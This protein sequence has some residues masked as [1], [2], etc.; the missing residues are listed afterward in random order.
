MGPTA[1]RKS[2]SAVIISSVTQKLPSVTAE[3]NPKESTTSFG[4]MHV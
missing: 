2:G 3:S 1:T 4:I